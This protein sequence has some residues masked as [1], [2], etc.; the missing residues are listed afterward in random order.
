VNPR[1]SF[2]TFL[3]T[4]Q[5]ESPS[6]IAS[7]LELPGPDTNQ[8]PKYVS[9]L[10]L[11]D[12][13][14]PEITSSTLSST[15]NLEHVA[16][17]LP[18]SL[19]V[20][21]RS[22]QLG[23]VNHPPLPTEL[24]DRENAD[25]FE[26]RSESTTYASNSLDT[27]SVS[28]NPVLSSFPSTP[29]SSFLLG[30]PINTIVGSDPRSISS[31]TITGTLKRGTHGTV[32]LGYFMGDPNRELHAMKILPRRVSRAQTAERE[33]DVLK[34]LAEVSADEE[35][36]LEYRKT[37]LHFLQQMATTY[38]NEDLMFIVFVRITPLFKVDQLP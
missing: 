21:P 13:E 7:E 15:H 37:G 12:L 9:F 33:L 24:P 27:S 4:H 5:P 23:H 17:S 35:Q 28:P 36:E 30:S 31:Y 26:P 32:I 19:T 22:S 25:R 6:E 38:F 18:S 16:S 10:H 14:H 29:V 34:W 11:D 2:R 1:H 8:P 3:S 20:S